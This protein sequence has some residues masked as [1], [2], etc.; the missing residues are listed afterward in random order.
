MKLYKYILIILILS[1]ALS[2]K[3]TSLTVTQP[4]PDFFL[5]KM[6]DGN[7][8]G[9]TV[10]GDKLSINGTNY[11]FEKPILGVGGV[12]NDGKG[13][14]I[15]TLPAGDSLGTVTMDKEAKETI[16]EIID[17]VGENNVLGVISGIIDSEDSDNIDA[18]R[19]TEK[20]DITEEDKKRIEN[21][22]NNLNGEKH[23]GDPEIIESNN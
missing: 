4:G 5:N 13:G 6:K 10:D 21:L 18:D 9:V 16:D 8:K 12:Y 3:K 1:A 14:Y 15:L 22:I 11:T 23:F 19:I 17:I 2:C 20:F 7:W